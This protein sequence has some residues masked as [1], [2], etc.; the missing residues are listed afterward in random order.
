[1]FRGYLAAEREVYF[2]GGVV[3]ASCLLSCHQISHFFVLE[4]K[5]TQIYLELNVFTHTGNYIYHFD[6]CL[7]VHH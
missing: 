6:I 4:G 5:G 3:M 7:T 2:E 1:V